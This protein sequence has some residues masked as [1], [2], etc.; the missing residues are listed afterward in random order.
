M[1]IMADQPW[2]GA[3]WNQPERLYENYYLPPRLTESAA[4]QT[5]DY[6][7][8]GATLGIPVL[9]CFCVYFYLSLTKM[10]EARWPRQAEDGVRDEGESKGGA[11][12]AGESCESSPVLSFEWLVITC[13]AGAIVL[14]VGFWFDGGLFKLPTAAIFW[15]LLELGS[16]GDRR[17]ERVAVN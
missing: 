6:L 10:S 12:E 8:L 11:Q 13:R 2:F 9:V 17:E 16:V 3:G 7:T 15:I 4:M 5:N 14:L 1:Q